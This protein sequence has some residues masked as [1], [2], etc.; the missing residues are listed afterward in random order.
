[1][2]DHENAPPGGITL[3]ALRDVAR[4]RMPVSG[5]LGWGP[6]LLARF[7]YYT[8]DEW[9]EAA[10]A[11]R[12]TQDTDWLDVGCGWRLLPQNPRLAQLLAERCRSVAGV[13]P[14]PSIQ[15]NPLLDEKYQCRLED[16]DTDRRYSLISLRMVAEHIANPD[17]AVAALGRLT[18]DG[19]LAIVYTVHKWAPV[20]LATAA[21]PMWLRHKAKRFLWGSNPSDTF[22]TVFRLNTRKRLARIFAAHG[23]REESYSLLDDCRTLQRWK[24]CLRAELSL[25][26]ALRA[27]GLRY[28][29][30]C[31]LGVYRRV[32]V[33]ANAAAV[34][35]LDGVGRRNPPTAGG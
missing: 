30:V 11:S 8:P 34:R 23:F 18:T 35:T 7:D 13:D 1:M 12:V 27:A 22:P 4:L 5:V 16:L 32:A 33:L 15:R 19:G 9:Y 20:S 14:D 25:R 29:E 3:E 6:A 28:P 17:A 2:R 31:I 21:T 24:T 10:L 26:R